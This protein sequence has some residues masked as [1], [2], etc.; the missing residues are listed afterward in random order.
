[1]ATSMSHFPTST[2]VVTANA[3]T[4]QTF[5]NPPVELVKNHIAAVESLRTASQVYHLRTTAKGRHTAKSPSKA[6]LDTLHHILADHYDALSAFLSTEFA[7][8]IS[9]IVEYAKLYADV[10]AH[11]YFYA[12]L[13]D[14]E[15]PTYIPPNDHHI[16]NELEG[17]N[18]AITL[19][20]RSSQ[21]VVNNLKKAQNRVN[22]LLASL[23]YSAEWTDE[24]LYAEA[25]ECGESWCSDLLSEV[26]A[27]LD[28]FKESYSPM[29]DY[30]DLQEVHLRLLQERVFDDANSR[31]DTLQA[32]LTVGGLTFPSPPVMPYPWH[33]VRR[34]G[35][36]TVMQWRAFSDS[37]I[38]ARLNAARDQL[39]GVLRVA[40]RLEN[41]G[42]RRRVSDRVRGALNRVSSLF[43]P[44]EI[45]AY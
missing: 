16:R 7:A 32:D 2:T 9:L 41:G 24:V 36:R 26:F 38:F 27:C 10:P 33:S 15:M 44:C 42:R 19:P 35:I 31:L 37:E 28:E 25:K 12:Q 14:P 1:M 40:S 17:L 11:M 45:D 21:E 43:T 30:F 23:K 20:W 8:P 22:E 29:I 6:R 13:V 39:L 18:A 5:T 3:S 4:N 34:R